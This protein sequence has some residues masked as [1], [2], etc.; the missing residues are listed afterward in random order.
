VHTSVGHT[1]KVGLERA[2][3]LAWLLVPL[4]AGVAIVPRPRAGDRKSMIALVLGASSTL[5]VLVAGLTAR[6]VLREDFGIVVY[7]MS[8]GELFIDA[9]P[10]LYV[11]LLAVGIGIGVSAIATL[12]ETNTQTGAAVL[13]LL[14]AGFAPQAPLRLLLMVLGACMLARSTIFLGERLV[15]ARQDAVDEK[16]RASLAELDRSLSDA[17]QPVEGE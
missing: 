7:G 9:M 6:S 4:A 1:I 8:S 5:A 15:T 17:P 16:E 13:L 14:S 12:D 3:E 11:M 10:S 2:G